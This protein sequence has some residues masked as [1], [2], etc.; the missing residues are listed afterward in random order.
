MKFTY[1]L[2]NS[3]LKK[4]DWQLLR[5]N[6][7]NDINCIVAYVLNT[8]ACKPFS[9][10][11]DLSGLYCPLLLRDNQLLLHYFVECDRGLLLDK[12]LP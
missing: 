1:S 6:K 2:K 5:D 8:G 12:L 11:M 10:T 4:F 3:R 9:I 7:G